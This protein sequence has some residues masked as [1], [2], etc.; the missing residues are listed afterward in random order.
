MFALFKLLFVVEQLSMAHFHEHR[1]Q[2][3][4]NSLRNSELP[5]VV[6]IEVAGWLKRH[7]E[8]T[9]RAMRGIGTSQLTQQAA[10]HNFLDPTK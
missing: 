6:G 3:A 9:G 8:L 10:L 2:A 5:V 4:A 1:S 7:R